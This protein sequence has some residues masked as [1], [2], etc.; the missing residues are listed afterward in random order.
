MGNLTNLCAVRSGRSTPWSLGM[1]NLQPLM[2]GILISWG[3]IG[4]PTIGL[5]SLSP[6]IWKQWE[7]IDP[8]A[9]ISSSRGTKFQHRVAQLFRGPEDDSKNNSFFKIPE[10]GASWLTVFT[11][12]IVRAFCM[13]S[14][15]KLTTLEKLTSF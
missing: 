10:N 5:M 12:T 6:I 4:A 7:L 1:G 14:H 8:I 9:Q 2:T 13:L 11:V 3:P 15:Y